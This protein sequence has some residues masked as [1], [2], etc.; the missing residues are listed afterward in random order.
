MV[1]CTLS[2]RSNYEYIAHF[3]KPFIDACL[4]GSLY[5][6]PKLRNGKVAYARTQQ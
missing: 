5:N 4:F 1:M 6:F 3:T 2:W